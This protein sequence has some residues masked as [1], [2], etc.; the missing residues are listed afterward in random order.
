MKITELIDKLQ[1]IA[2][3][4]P[5]SDVAVINTESAL[6]YHVKSL[7]WEGNEDGLAHSTTWLKVTEW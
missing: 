5:G 2:D 6:V 4:H 7:E 3:E 1:A